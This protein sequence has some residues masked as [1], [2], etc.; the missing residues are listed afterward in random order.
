MKISEDDV[1]IKVIQL[2][3]LRTEAK[4]TVGCIV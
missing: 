4:S 3:A 2:I 1:P